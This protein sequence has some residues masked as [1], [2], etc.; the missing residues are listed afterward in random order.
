MTAGAIRSRE[1]TQRWDGSAPVEHEAGLVKICGL[2]EPAHA[3]A[4]VAAGA[5]LLGFVFAPARRRVSVEE[6]RLSV[7]AAREAANDWR[8]GVL[9][10]GVFVDA[11]AEEMNEVVAGAEI[12]LLQL[13]G[14]E[15]PETLERLTRPVV[16][17]LRPTLGA[18]TAEVRVEMKRFRDVPNAPVAFLIDGYAPG[19]RGG[20]GARA[21][22]ALVGDIS[23]ETPVMLAGGLDADNVGETIGM[24]RPAGVD[25]SS[26]VESDG[27]KDV[28]KIEAFFAAARQAFG[29]RRR[30]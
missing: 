2:R 12:D 26:G 24:T 11:T 9:A 6:A 27:V 28:A 3:V 7:E 23:R 14:D 4:A 1:D 8:R 10:V 22:W 25:V 18:T 5:D 16:K 20:V 29:E 15:A 13:H 21:S 19:A 17:V 30:G